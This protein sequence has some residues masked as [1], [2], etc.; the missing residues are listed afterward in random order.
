VG[1]LRG[2]TAAID[3]FAAEYEDDL[4]RMAVSAPRLAR[5]QPE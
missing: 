2:I 1:K 3:L 5:A 4:R